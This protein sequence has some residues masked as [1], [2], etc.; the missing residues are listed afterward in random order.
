MAPHP[1]ASRP[2]G[3]WRQSKSSQHSFA[4]YTN[5]LQMTSSAC[6]RFNGQ[7]EQPLAPD[8]YAA[9]FET[10]AQLR[11]AKTVVSVAHLRPEEARID[12]TDLLAVQVCTL[13]VVGLNK[14]LTYCSSS[15]NAAASHALLPPTKADQG[16]A[17]C[18]C[19]ML[20]LMVCVT[21]SCVLQMFERQNPRLYRRAIRAAESD[22]AKMLGWQ[23][24]AFNWA[25]RKNPSLPAEVQA[26]RA[27][28]SA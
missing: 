11:R 13:L 20:V 2:S 10:T 24:R 3:N 26:L 28:S 1:R 14:M 15:S 4:F 6:A 12:A 27:A 18:C 21:H 7:L 9:A 8:F 22:G 25:L 19:D 23:M 5:H 17:S 16:F